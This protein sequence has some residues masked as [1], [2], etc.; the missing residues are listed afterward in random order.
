M[1]RPKTKHD[2]K[3]DSRD[4]DEYDEAVFHVLVYY[5][6]RYVVT[7]PKILQMK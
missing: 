4:N 6:P 2:E 5:Q 3:S 7:N 1:V